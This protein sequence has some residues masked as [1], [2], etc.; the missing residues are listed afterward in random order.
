MIRLSLVLSFLFLS[1][2]ICCSQSADQI[3]DIDTT[4][5][6]LGDEYEGNDF[7]GSSDTIAIEKK[8][9]DSTVIDNLKNDPDY[10]YTQPPTI[11]E[12]LWDR[13]K[14]WIAALIDAI[15]RGATSTGV[16]RIIMS[17]IG[18]VLLSAIIMMLLKVDAFRVFYSGADRG[19]TINPLFHEN[20]HE[21]DFEKL[22]REAVQKEDYRQ[23]TRFILLYALKLLADKNLIKWEGGKTNHDYVDE[24]TTSHLKTGFNEL[25]YYFDYTWYGHFEVNRET[26]T[27]IENTF[28]DWRSKI[29][30]S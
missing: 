24:L 10:Q 23:G 18:I 15:L 11:A 6:G 25:S 14:R 4:A 1:A 27:K 3:I 12:S 8:S 30:K 28:S 2:T 7:V 20:I 9:F 17:I 21:M 29:N 26:F 13:F 16:G 19:K 5:A 22:L